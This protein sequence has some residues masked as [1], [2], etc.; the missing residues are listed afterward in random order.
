ML[1]WLVFAE[2]NYEKVFIT[3]IIYFWIFS[4]IIKLSVHPITS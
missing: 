2:S 4:L 3:I 1:T